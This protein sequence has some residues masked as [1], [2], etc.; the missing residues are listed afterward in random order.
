MTGARIAGFGAAAPGQSREAP[1]YQSRGAPE[2]STALAS[3]QSLRVSMQV[4]GDETSVLTFVDGLRTLPRL[5]VVDDVEFRWSTAR[6]QNVFGNNVP[7]GDVPG[8]R[9]AGTDTAGDDAESSSDEGLLQADLSAR[10]FVQ[11]DSSPQ[12]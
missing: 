7:G 5:L 9:A 6:A 8:S 4:S 10:M 12:P 2:P 11:P 3:I 1:T